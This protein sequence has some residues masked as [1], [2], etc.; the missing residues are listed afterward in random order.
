MSDIPFSILQAIKVDVRKTTERD[1]LLGCEECYIIP[2]YIF[3]CHF[4]HRLLCY[5]C[6]ARYFILTTDNPTFERIKTEIELYVTT[7]VKQVESYTG[8]ATTT[9]EFYKEHQIQYKPGI[10]YKTE[11]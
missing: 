1:L 7:I 6:Y 2:K 3:K 8:V 11:G 10:I 4:L 9:L 5:S